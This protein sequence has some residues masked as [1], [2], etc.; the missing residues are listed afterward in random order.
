MMKLC[1][2]AVKATISCLLLVYLFSTVDRH[3]IVLVISRA[4]WY[5]VLGS[6]VILVL[7]FLISCYKW[8]VLLRSDEVVCPYGALARYYLVGFYFNNFLPTSIGGDAVRIYLVARRCGKR[9]VGFNSVF[10]ERL[11]GLLA[12]FVLGWVGVGLGEAS[13]GVGVGG[14]FV[15]AFGVSIVFVLILVDG[16]ICSFAKRFFSA[17]L[18]RRADDVLSGIRKYFRSASTLWMMTWTSVLFQSLMVLVYYVGAQGLSLNISFLDLMVV[19]PVVTVLMLMPVSLN[20]LG[21]REGGFVILLSQMGV[22]QAEAL[23]LSLLIYA[24]TLLFSLAGGVL[25]FVGRR[26]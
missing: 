11:S 3:S 10:A 22:N 13:L 6:F 23:S 12:L 14:V 2:T 17:K 18:W 19:V 25:F 5:L 4:D 7:G 16:R 15:C 21:V 8:W 9:I 26:R 24:L 20:G 1:L